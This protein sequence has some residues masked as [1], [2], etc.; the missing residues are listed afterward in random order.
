MKKFLLY[1]I[2]LGA[3]GGAVYI[4][5]PDLLLGRDVPA[6]HEK[7]KISKNAQPEK[8]AAD[9][10]LTED[11]PDA[12]DNEPLQEQS[13]QQKEQGLV[14]L[15]SPKP[16]VVVSAEHALRA[17]LPL[18]FPENMEARA[19]AKESGRPV[20]ILWYGTDSDKLVAPWNKLAKQGLPVVF[21]QINETVGSMQNEHERKQMLPTGAFNTLPV[22]V[23]LAPDD[24]LLAIYTGKMLYSAAAMA[25][26]VERT[27]KSAGDYM[28]L[29][30]QARSAP[31]VEGAT[32]AAKALAMMPHTTA[33]RNHQLK[34]IINKKDPDHQTVFRYLYCMDHIGMFQEL[35]ALMEGGHGSAGV[36][37]GAERKFT[38]AMNL[39]KRVLAT[40]D[41][42]TELQQQ[43]NAAMAYILREMYLATKQ[44]QL[45]LQLVDCYKLVARLDPESEYGKGAARL[46]RYWDDSVPYVFESPYY[47]SG[48]MTAGFEKEWRV[49]VS[50]QVDAPGKYSF[51]L[52]PLSGM[53]GRMTT[54][55]YKLF[56]NDKHVC[57]ATGPADQDAK[58][59]IF[60]VPHAL[61]G[62]VEVRFRVQCFDGWYN[63]SGKM[64]MKRV[65]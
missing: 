44:P 21:G 52:E 28:K 11:V 35:N 14:P 57:D 32:A 34:D 18:P 49:N 12:A 23:L 37:K 65:E 16:E 45:R 2:V 30:E 5:N 24:T 48:D 61:S 26:G 54:R 6:L 22:A 13:A 47:D 10:W 29:V 39:V 58:S 31:G 19:K 59:V 27:L 64:V 46:A 50:E 4:Y 7:K 56:A 60:D 25:K 62:R 41:L 42:S 43:W 33:R 40:P 3:I 17:P 38:E 9:A 20:L 15:E 36:L 51:T 1:L 8:Q 55:G 53:N 63:C